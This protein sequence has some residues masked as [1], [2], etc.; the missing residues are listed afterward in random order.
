MEPEYNGIVPGQENGEMSKKTSRNL[1]LDV[2]SLVQVDG[3]LLSLTSV[4]RE[5][6]RLNSRPIGDGQ[7]VAK[8]CMV[9]VLKVLRSNHAE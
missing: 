1:A 5:I 6:N 4:V 7:D 9:Y 8:A 3:Q 2:N